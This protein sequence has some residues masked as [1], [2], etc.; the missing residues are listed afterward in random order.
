MELLKEDLMC[1][2]LNI[3]KKFTEKKGGNLEQELLKMSS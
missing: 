1:Y 2:K 3:E